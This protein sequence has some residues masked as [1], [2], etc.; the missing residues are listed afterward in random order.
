[1]TVTSIH[2][3]KAMKR[4]SENRET[5]EKLWRESESFATLMEDY[6]ECAEAVQRWTESSLPDAHRRQ[7]EYTALL[8]E[9]EAEITERIKAPSR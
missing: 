2:L 9:L 7:E 5:V 8:R 4:F 3:H 6:A 1:M